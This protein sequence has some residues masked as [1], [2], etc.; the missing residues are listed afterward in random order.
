MRSTR[1]NPVSP[2]TRMSAI[3]WG[4]VLCVSTGLGQPASPVQVKAQGPTEERSAA[5]A[6]FHREAPGDPWMP[7]PSTPPPRAI[8]HSGPWRLGPYESI[9]VNVDEFGN[10]ILGDAAN[11]PSIAIDPTDPSRIVIGWRQFDSVESDFRQA[12]YA[13]SHDAGQTWTFPGSLTP[14]VF[15]SDPVLDVDSNGV[16]Y[17]VSINFEEMRLF[18]SFDGGVTWDDPPLQ[19]FDHFGDKEVDGDR[20]YRR[21]QRWARLHRL[22]GSGLY[23]IH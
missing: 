3:A 23:A 1:S 13:Y 4:L 9:Q 21:H 12:G 15:G 7:R 5:G 22:V 8:A 14:G 10:N 19:V 6:E 20:P 17:Y 16:F 11:E 2:A 18:R